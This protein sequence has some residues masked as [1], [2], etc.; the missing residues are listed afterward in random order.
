MPFIRSLVSKCYTYIVILILLLSVIIPLY[1]CCAKKELVY[2][3]I[4]APFSHQPSSYSKYIKLNMC[5]SYNI[6]SVSDAK[7]TFLVYLTSY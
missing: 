6:K 3:I 2:I 1:S 4:T 7:Y 5:S